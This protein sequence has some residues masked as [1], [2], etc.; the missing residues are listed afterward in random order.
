MNEKK[1]YYIELN[2]SFF[3]DVLEQFNIERFDV[4]TLHNLYN[5]VI[6]IFVGSLF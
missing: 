2:M 3:C 6:F 4:D 5:L 1:M